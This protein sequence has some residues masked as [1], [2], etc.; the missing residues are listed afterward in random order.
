MIPEI[1][2][3]KVREKIKIGLKVTEKFII[4][5]TIQSVF[6]QRNFLAK[7]IHIINTPLVQLGSNITERQK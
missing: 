4:Q 6:D 1:V 7:L 2:Q 3:Q 5:M